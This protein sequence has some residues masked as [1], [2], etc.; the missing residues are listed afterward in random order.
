MVGWN[1]G[2]QCWQPWGSDRWCHAPGD[3]ACCTASSGLIQIQAL[4]R[5]FHADGL[6]Q[7]SGV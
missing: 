5:D 2:P 3:T 1:L 7:E 4:E 6:Q